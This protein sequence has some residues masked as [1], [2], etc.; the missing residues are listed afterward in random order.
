MGSGEV[1]TPARHSDI[2]FKLLLLIHS[3]FSPSNT[4]KEV[5]VCEL[6]VKSNHLQTQPLVGR[7][8]KGP[9]PWVTKGSPENGGDR[10]SAHCMVDS[11]P[12]QPDSP[13]EA[14][15]K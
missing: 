4:E 12:T 11:Q 7:S 6:T 5:R 9:L 13:V 14:I 8:R 3:L 2:K 1:G 15:K 10:N